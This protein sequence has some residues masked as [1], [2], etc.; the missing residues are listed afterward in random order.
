[1]VNLYVKFHNRIY[2]RYKTTAL[3]KVLGFFW[4]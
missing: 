1:M 3:Q 4:K 2:P